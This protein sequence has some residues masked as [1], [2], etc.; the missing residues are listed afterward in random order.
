MQ[1]LIQNNLE[2]TS[3]II[4]IPGNLLKNTGKILEFCQSGNVGTLDLKS[5]KMPFY[6][7]ATVKV[8]T[9]NKRLLRLPC[10]QGDF[11]DKVPLLC[12]F[13]WGKSGAFVAQGSIHNC[14]L[15]GVNYSLNNG[16]YCNKVPSFTLAIWS[17]C[18]WTERF[19]NGLCTHFSRFCGLKSSRNSSRLINHR[20]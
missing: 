7:S 15:L 13:L 5:L 18:V 14:D 10:L 1:I 11:D 3:K 16:L 4:E 20:C 9:D 6:L 2:I 8:D 19:N 17:T 12:Q